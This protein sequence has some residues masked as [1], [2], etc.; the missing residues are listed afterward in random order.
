MLR[1]L[2]EKKITEDLI[3]QIHKWLMNGVL[4]DPGEGVAGEYRK[5]KIG[6]EGS[7]ISRVEAAFVKGRMKRFFS[8]DMIQDNKEN[9]MEEATQS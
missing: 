5:G 2:S 1:E 4:S 7:K 6:I 9:L 8:E 3:L